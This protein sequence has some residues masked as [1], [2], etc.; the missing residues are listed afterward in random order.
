MHPIY[1][2]ILINDKLTQNRASDNIFAISEATNT[3]RSADNNST[4]YLEGKS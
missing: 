3:E 1:G 4:V 2:I